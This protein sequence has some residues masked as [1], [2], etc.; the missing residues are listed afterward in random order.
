MDKISGN[1][2]NYA[3]DIVLLEESFNNR[4]YLENIAG[5]N[6]NLFMVLKKITGGQTLAEYIKVKVDTLPM[7]N[8]VYLF[9]NDIIKMLDTDQVINIS[10]YRD[11]LYFRQGKMQTPIT[12]IN[13]RNSVT[14]FVIL[15]AKLDMAVM[16]EF[17][18][19]LSLFN[20]EINKG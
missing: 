5:F 19:T 1:E 18:K 3:T 4:K 11:V 20:N 6:K 7:T 17:L 10:K 15:I 8:I 2:Y 16:V 12:S 14:E 9:L 13:N